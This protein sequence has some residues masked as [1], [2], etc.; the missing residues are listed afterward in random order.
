MP[1]VFEKMPNMKVLYLQG[2]KMIKGIK[3]YRKT[4]TVK[5]PLLCY[6]DDRPVFPE[7]RRHA[8]A[9]AR[10]GIEEERK[11]RDRIRE[12]N[13]EKDEK[14]RKAF[15][16]MMDN[17]KEQRR[18]AR[19]AEKKAQDEKQAQENTDPNTLPDQSKENASK[20]DT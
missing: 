5:L 18:I 6:L 11:E 16:D 2:N 4:L 19:E 9:F 15:R 1:E 20:E 13:N 12:E 3:A 14:N 7:D 17:A 8:D 10:G